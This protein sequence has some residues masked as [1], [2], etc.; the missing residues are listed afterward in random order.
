M[1]S[2]KE[3][4]EHASHALDEP[5]GWF[6]RVSLRMHLFMCVDCRRYV[7]QLGLV[8]RATQSAPEPDE[9]GAAA[10]DQTLNALMQRKAED[11]AD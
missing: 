4:T 8:S 3:V 9:P 5:Q 1:L 6:A 11:P 2:C 7:T 10:V